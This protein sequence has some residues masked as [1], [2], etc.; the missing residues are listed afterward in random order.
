MVGAADPD[1]GTSGEEGR[2]FRG[3]FTCGATWNWQRFKIRLV[4][5]H[6]LS[7]SLVFHYMNGRVCSHGTYSRSSRCSY[8][9]CYIMK[10]NF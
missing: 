7:T 10:D 4:H 5:T 1:M 9:S 2:S 3:G 6:T 8:E